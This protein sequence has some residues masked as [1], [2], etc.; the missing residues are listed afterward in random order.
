M[1][2]EQTE[3]QGYTSAAKEQIFL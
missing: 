3:T 2:L 1:R